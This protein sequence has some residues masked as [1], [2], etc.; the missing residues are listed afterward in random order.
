MKLSGEERR[1]KI[2]ELLS[3]SSEPLSGSKLASML[4]VSR[5]V[6][7]TDIA[8][9]R[10]R[11][12]EI[13][14]TNTGYVILKSNYSGMIRRIFKVCHTDEEMEDELNCISDLGGCVVDVYIN[15]KVYGTLSAPLNIRSRRDIQN[16]LNDIKSGVSTP[17]KNVTQ[18]Y[19]FH[20][21]EAESKKILDEIEEAL[22][23][24]GYLLESL[25]EKPSYEAKIYS[26]E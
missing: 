15:H 18:G 14:A 16:F 7:V 3:S 23:K 24:K 19:H 26:A 17:L 6:I 4:E 8:I 11:R 10:E 20:T 2:I 5:Q 21:V 13:L 22:R 25:S 12:P 9:L 1:N